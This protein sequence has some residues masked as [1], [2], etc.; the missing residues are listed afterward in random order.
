ME[1]IRRLSTVFPNDHLLIIAEM[2]C[3]ILLCDRFGTLKR[4]FEIV[5]SCVIGILNDVR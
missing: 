4:G 3:E 1:G 5:V 2:F